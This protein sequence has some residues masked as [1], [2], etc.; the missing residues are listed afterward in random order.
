MNRYRDEGRSAYFVWCFFEA[1]VRKARVL[2]GRGHKKLGRAYLGRYLNAT[3]KESMSTQDT[4]DIKE[5]QAG[6]REVRPASNEEKRSYL[7]VEVLATRT[8]HGRTGC[9]CALE[10]EGPLKGAL[11]FF[12]EDWKKWRGWSESQG[13]F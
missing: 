10:L 9:G 5:G 7:R 13:S 11:D 8:R 2:W 6:R 12:R 3:W 4:V 1:G